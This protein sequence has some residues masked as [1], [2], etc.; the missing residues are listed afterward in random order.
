MSATPEPAL[1]NRQR[2][3]CLTMEGDFNFEYVDIAVEHG[4][5]GSTWRPRDHPAQV[6]GYSRANRTGQG[7]EFTSRVLCL[8]G[9]PRY[10][11]FASTMRATRRRTPTSRAATASSGTSARTS[12]G[13]NHWPRQGG[14]RPMKAGLQRGP[15]T[16]F[17]GVHTSGQLRRTAQPEPCRRCAITGDQAI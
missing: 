7:A 13:S 1:A 15:A 12:S 2:I 17:S 9:H 11:A 5:C 14:D 8:G 4:M 3:K 10:S 6:G 16:L